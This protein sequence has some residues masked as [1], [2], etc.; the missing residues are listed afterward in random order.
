[1]GDV[2]VRI[3]EARYLAERIPDAELVELQGVDHFVSMDPDQIL[4]E[5]E[6]FLRDLDSPVEP[7]R[8]LETILMTDLVGSTETAQRLGDRAWSSLLDSH[9]AAVRAVLGEFGGEE[10]DVTGDGMLAVFDG[11]ARAIRAA[12]AIRHR[13]ASLGLDVRIGIHTGEVERR[14]AGVRGLAVHVAARVAGEGGAGDVLVT[15]TTHDL[16]A[17]SGISLTPLG[18]RELRGL[19]EPWQVY[20]VTAVAPGGS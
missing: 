7:T 12:A 10:I 5:V 9:F 11:P 8:R 1:V 17:G 15:S 2:D 6:R 16:V 14:G 20:R 3:E 4:D 13:L 18:P 19:G